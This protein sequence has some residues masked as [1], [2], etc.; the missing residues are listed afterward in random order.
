[1]QILSCEIWK[2]NNDMDAWSSSPNKFHKKVCYIK[3]IGPYK[4]RIKY[5][6]LKITLY[7]RDTRGD[8]R[9]FEGRGGEVT[10]CGTYYYYTVIIRTRV[11]GR[12]IDPLCS[13]RRVVSKLCH[14]L[15][16]INIIYIMFS[17]RLFS[18]CFFFLL[19]KHVDY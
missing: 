14:R 12:L 9:H 5:R 15:L 1:V 19:L 7:R 6:A 8:Q 16:Y 11:V 2:N 18:C 10:L 17:L 4:Y 3:K 13:S